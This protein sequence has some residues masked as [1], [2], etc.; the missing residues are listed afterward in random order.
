MTP[1]APL[2]YFLA[3]DGQPRGPLNAAMVLNLRRQ[4]TI[5]GRTLIC[6]EGGP[7]W[8]PLDQILDQLSGPAAPP[9]VPPVPTAP[10][11]AASTMP[12]SFG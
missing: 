6:P 11:V 4:G 9:P 12:A 5:D 7:A 8:V 2:N 3:I 10:P 1:T